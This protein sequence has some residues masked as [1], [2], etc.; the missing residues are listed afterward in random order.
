MIYLWLKWVY[1]VKGGVSVSYESIEKIIKKYEGNVYV[2]GEK[3]SRKYDKQYERK[4]AVKNRHLLADN[5]FNEVVFH[6]NQSEKEQVHYLIDKFQNFRKLHG[7]ASNETIILSFIFYVK[8]KQN[9]L[10]RLD[11]YKICKKYKLNNRTFEII[12]CKIIL[13]LLEETEIKR[14]VTTQYDHNILLKGE[15]K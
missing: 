11:E 7:K 12:L 8:M 5:L 6:I 15:I 2:P 1:Y 14:S 10:I 13:K 3:R 4:V 9:T